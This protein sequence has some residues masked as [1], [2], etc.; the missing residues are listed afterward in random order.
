[1]SPLLRGEIRLGVWS[2]LFRRRAAE[3]Y[4]PRLEPRKT[5]GARGRRCMAAA[6][7]QHAEAAGALALFATNAFITS[8]LFHVAYLR[9]M[10]SIEAAFIGL[11][12]YIRDHFP[13]LTWFP[14]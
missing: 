6:L 12:R 14:L 9:Q 1:F 11:A 5:L 3:F 7:R 4:N 10:G 13:H 8:R 2:L